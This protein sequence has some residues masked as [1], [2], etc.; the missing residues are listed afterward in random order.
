MNSREAVEFLQKGPAT[1]QKKPPTSN[2]VSGGGCPL[3]P[4]S[5]L[6]YLIRTSWAYKGKEYK[7]YANLY[8]NGIGRMVWLGAFSPLTDG[9]AK[10][11]TLDTWCGP[12]KKTRRAHT[13]ARTCA[14]TTQAPR[15]PLPVRAPHQ[16]H[17][18]ALFP[19]GLPDRRRRVRPVGPPR[20]AHL[21]GLREP[22]PLL[23]RLED[24]ERAHE[25]VVHAHHRA[26]VV[27]LA[28]VV[29]RTEY[30]HQ[31]PASEEFVPVLHHL[32]SAHAA[33][34]STHTGNVRQAW[35]DG[36]DA[37]PPRRVW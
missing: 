8:N 22:L 5:R 25:R 6:T 29:G 26:G 19:P 16:R 15:F 31:L 35:A 4:S 33:H 14:R 9:P 18:S 3:A 12:D 24:L 13:H 27:E 23:R 21:P 34:A 17:A 36:D 10:T 20:A 2:V 11:N 37:P 32:H 1:A 28:A 30:R 7:H